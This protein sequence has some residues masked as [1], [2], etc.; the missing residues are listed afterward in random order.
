[1]HR[2]GSLTSPLIDIYWVL[3]YV[4][5]YYYKIYSI[6]ITWSIT[7]KLSAYIIP[8]AISAALLTA[9][10]KPKE[11]FSDCVFPD[12]TDIAAPDWICDK[13]VEGIAIY[14]IGSTTKSAAG[15]DYMKSM[16]ATSARVQLAQNMQV[17]VRNMIKQYVETTGQTD[18]ETVDKVMTSVTKQITNQTLVGTKIIKTRTSPSGNLYVLVGMSEDSVQKA[19]E[20]ALKTS[21]R[22]D[23][24]LWQQFKAKQSQD[25][26]AAEISKFNAN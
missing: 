18:S 6:T 22:N 14:A 13:P 12:A 10:G 16:A 7:M 1:M 2:H 9:C 15:Y 23:S 25:E 21:M 17:Q 24:A 11:D 19:S 8:F 5:G 3:S 26:L 20:K 4:I